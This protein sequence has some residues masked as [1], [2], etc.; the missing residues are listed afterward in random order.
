MKFYK[1]LS[2]KVLAYDDHAPDEIIQEGLI[3]ITEAEAHI[4]RKPTRTVAE[5]K[6]GALSRINTAYEIA[7][8]AITAGY[9]DGEVA[10]WPKQETE[11]RAWLASNATPTPWIDAAATVRGITKADLVSKIIS[12][13]E[14]FAAASGQL[15][16]KRQKLRDQISA[17]GD[18]PTQEQLDAIQW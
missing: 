15:S 4:L 1:D 6:S 13:A 12:N 5:M 18:N 9:P 3:P 16:G 7:V 10:S 2:G 11:A 8:R 17:L 14:L